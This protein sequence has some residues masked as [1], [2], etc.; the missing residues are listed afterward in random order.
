[1]ESELPAELIHRIQSLLSKKEAAATCILS[2]SWL[3]AWNTTPHLKFHNTKLKIENTL[4]RYQRLNLPIQSLDIRMDIFS[5]DTAPLTRWIQQVTSKSCLKELSLCLN[6]YINSFSVPKEI[7]SCENLTM[8]NVINEAYSISS[9]YSSTITITR[10][11]WICKNNMIKCVSLCVL[12]LIKVNISEELFNNLLSTCTLLEKI[13]L[14]HCIGLKTVNVN[15]LSRLIELKIHL[16]EEDCVKVKD[17][18]C[19]TELEISPSCDFVFE[20]DNV[21]SLSIFRYRV[22]KPLLPLSHMDQVAARVTHLQIHGLLIWNNEFT[23][24]IKS[25][26]PFL[27]DLDVGVRYWGKYKDLVITNATLKRLTLK[28]DDYSRNDVQ[29]DA[30]NLLYFSYESAKIRTLLFPVV[31]PKQIDL[32]INLIKPMDLSFFLKLREV[33][34]LS[35][36]FDIYIRGTSN[37]TLLT[38]D[39]TSVKNMRTRFLNPATNVKQLHIETNEHVWK[40]TL[41]YDLFF[42]V[43][44]PSGLMV[45]L[46]VVKANSDNRLFSDLMVRGILKNKKKRDLKNVQ[47]RSSGNERWEDVTL[48]S[49]KTFIDPSQPSSVDF[50]LEWFTQ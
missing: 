38:W 50:K 14:C 39:D 44:H 28:L 25:K 10:P 2:K 42:P 30:P 31:A 40:H 9:I 41:Y 19:L 21:P 35:S 8:I 18:P 3:H 33:L 11:L 4:E 12:K 22:N 26:F 29:V 24:M 43:C 16:N 49:W 45:E 5:Y 6:P 36:T 32:K 7:F 23:D 34:N 17:L 46:V 15:D 13:Q 47:M 20:I 27:A 37:D 1:M 48:R